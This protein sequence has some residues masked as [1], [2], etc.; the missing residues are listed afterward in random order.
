MHCD[1]Y[2]IIPI[3]EDFKDINGNKIINAYFITNFKKNAYIVGTNEN[4][5]TDFEENDDKLIK[6]Y[7]NSINI[8]YYK[9]NAS[10]TV[11]NILNPKIK[12]VKGNSKRKNTDY[13]Y[14]ELLVALNLLGL[15]DKYTYEDIIKFSNEMFKKG[16]KFKCRKDKLDK[17]H[18]DLKS[19]YDNKTFKKSY[20]DNFIKEL[21]NIN[22]DLNKIE[23]VYLTGKSYSEYPEIV[24]QNKMYEGMKP[25][26][27]VYFKLIDEELLQGISCKQSFKC[28]CTNKIA[29]DAG[30]SFELNH[31]INLREKLLNDNG[32]T[33][34]NFKN[35]R[36]CESG[37]GKISKILST[38][39]HYSIGEKIDYWK[40]LENHIIKYKDYFINGVI[41]S[42][43]QGTILPYKVYEYDGEKL[44]NTLDRKLKKEKCNI[45]VSNIFCW[46]KSGIRDASKI[47]FDFM[48]DNEVMYNLEV[49]F[50]G[51][52]FGGKGRPQLFILKEKKEDIDKYIKARVKFSNSN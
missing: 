22:F 17:Y 41:N 10:K 27:D 49:R 8:K 43:C 16:N 44:I 33:K 3:S 21:F 15:K 12:N 11:N 42:M 9:T 50:K 38:K 31:L 2:S 45:R 51:E 52:Y 20:I 36:K 34:K 25:N 32:I 46:S 47:W 30:L 37:D 40:E 1:S 5:H 23:C 48:Y 19:S 35:H 14:T 13:Q 6:Q 18:A 26:S 7:L 28:P 39:N 29:E 24:E 4:D